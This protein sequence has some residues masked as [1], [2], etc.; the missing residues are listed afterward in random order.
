MVEFILSEFQNVGKRHSYTQI[1][2]L[3]TLTKMKFT[4]YTH[5]CFLFQISWCL[6]F[7]PIASETAHAQMVVSPSSTPK[8]SP[9]LIREL[10]CLS[11]NFQLSHYP[12]EH[13]YSV[14]SEPRLWQPCF[15]FQMSDSIKYLAT[16]SKRKKRPVK[17]KQMQTRQINLSN[18][19]Q[20]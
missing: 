17:S 2:K 13:I 19:P 14:H 5:S 1:R 7:F 12:F 18:T 10:A 8:F 15:Q 4:K 16:K 9:F 3:P 11:S 20:K 6:F